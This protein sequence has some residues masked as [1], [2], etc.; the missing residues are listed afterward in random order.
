VTLAR[1]L[2]AAVLLTGAAAQTLFSQQRPD[3]SGEWVL[4]RMASSLA[5]ESAAI[6][7]GVVR[8]EHRE[9]TVQWS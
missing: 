2:V 3:F 5:A 8:I 7:S 9:P 1:L 4:N 6:V